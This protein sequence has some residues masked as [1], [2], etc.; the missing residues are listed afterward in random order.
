MTDPDANAFPI[1]EANGRY[2]PLEAG[3]TKR[4]Y[5]AAMAMQGLLACEK[6][7]WHFNTQNRAKEAVTNADE[8]I[9]ALRAE[10]QD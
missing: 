4:E 3:L 6:E 2:N 5:F 9:K 1:F 10:G 8:L 7:D